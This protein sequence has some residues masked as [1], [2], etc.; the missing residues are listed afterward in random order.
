MQVRETIWGPL[1]EKNAAPGQLIA[2]SW[3][4]HHIDAVNLGHLDLETVSN[5]EAAMDV[6]NRI[7]MPPQNFVV[8]DA[9]GNIVAEFDVG[10]RS[11]DR[12]LW[13]APIVL[14]ETPDEG[15]EDKEDENSQ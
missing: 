5:V 14:I 3:I 12:W 6:G 4:A 11:L 7:G 10:V 13:D 2:V 1:L 9:E 8:G 15:E